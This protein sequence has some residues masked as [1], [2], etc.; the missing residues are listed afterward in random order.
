M[1]TPKITNITA[2]SFALA[3]AG[4]LSICVALK[5]SNMILLAAI[6][7]VSR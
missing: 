6:L 2:S 4:W 3:I 5:I 7:A 1:T